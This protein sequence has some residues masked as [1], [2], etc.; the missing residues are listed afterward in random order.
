MWFWKALRHLDDV[1]LGR[2]VARRSDAKDGR[3]PGD[4]RNYEFR[5]DSRLVP[6]SGRLLLHAGCLMK[7]QAKVGLLF[8]FEVR[9]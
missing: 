5:F 1:A 8:P 7:W 6:K 9:V 4:V 2:D 3:Q